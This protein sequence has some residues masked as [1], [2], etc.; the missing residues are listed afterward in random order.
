MKIGNFITIVAALMMS[1]RAVAAQKE[2]VH[3]VNAVGADQVLR[4]IAGLVIVLVVIVLVAW[5][6]RK[7]LASRTYGGISL[8]VVGGASLGGKDR[9]VVIEVDGDNLLLGVSP[10]GITRLHKLKK[11]TTETRENQSVPPLPERSGNFIERLN[12]EIRR[13]SIP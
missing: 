2:V 9:V 6:A 11:T 3:S 13:K 7:Y 4:V 10:G 1:G 5:L 8:R 12:E